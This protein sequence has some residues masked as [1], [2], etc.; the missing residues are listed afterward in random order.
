[1]ATEKWIGGS[2]AGL[3]WTNAFSPSTLSAIASGNAIIS[4][5]QIDNSTALDLFADVSINLA[6]AAF[7]APNYV[8]VYIYPLNSDNATFGDGRFGTSAAGPPA[9]SYWVGNII[10]VATTGAQEGTARGIIIPPGKFKWLLY[11]QGGVAF[12]TTSSGNTCLYRT[13]NR[14]VV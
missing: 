9:S 6:S 10:L 12:A 14:Q 1:M 3:T 8:G 2:G 5:L 4:D 7:A 13:Y 11:N